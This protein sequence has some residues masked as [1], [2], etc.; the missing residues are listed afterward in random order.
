MNHEIRDVTQYLLHLYE[1]NLQ[2]NRVQTVYL[3][4]GS[5]FLRESIT[6]TLEKLSQIPT[7]PRSTP[8]VA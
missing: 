4:G 2:H 5:R 6:E 7:S 3:R 8:S 1:D